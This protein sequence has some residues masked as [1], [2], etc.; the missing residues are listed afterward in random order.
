MLPLWRTETP[1]PN[2]ESTATEGACPEPGTSTG[3]PIVKAVIVP[4]SQIDQILQ[5]AETGYNL[6][7]LKA[8][9]TEAALAQR[10]DE[11]LDV[12]ASRGDGAAEEAGGH[13]QQRC[14]PRLQTTP[15][16]Q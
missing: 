8:G 10:G 3:G 2:G 1:L 11:V 13:K 15:C 6:S 12:V 4:D 9:L 5:I 7:P 16:T 14:P